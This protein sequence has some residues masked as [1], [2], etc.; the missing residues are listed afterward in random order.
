L[1]PDTTKAPVPDLRT[2]VEDFRSH[3]AAEKLAAIR[4]A[5][6]EDM[7]LG[8]ANGAG[9]GAGHWKKMRIGDILKIQLSPNL[10]L[11]GEKRS[12]E[13]ISAVNLLTVGQA[14]LP[15]RWFDTTTAT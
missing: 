8:S 3:E 6:D 14:S 13:G 15:R 5:E 2:L 4:L 9:L 1:P 12:I 7:E 10:H 11:E